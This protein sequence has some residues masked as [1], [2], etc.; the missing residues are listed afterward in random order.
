MDPARSDGRRFFDLPRELRDEIYKFCY[1]VTPHTC[2]ALHGYADIPSSAL[3][4][5]CKQA[6]QEASPI[7]HKGLK[8][9]LLHDRV[10]F[11]LRSDTEDSVRH[12]GWQKISNERFDIWVRNGPDDGTEVGWFVYL[13][14]V[15]QGGVRD[16]ELD[17][18]I[19]EVIN[20]FDKV[21]GLTKLYTS[22]PHR[23]D[24][25]SPVA[26]RLDKV[27]DRVCQVLRKTLYPSRPRRVFAPARTS[28]CQ[29]QPI[30]LDIQQV[31][32]FVHDWRHYGAV[33]VGEASAQTAIGKG[34]SVAVR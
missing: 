8:A 14:H 1:Q 25:W 27:M 6:Y 31:A 5:T 24:Y 18:Y 34:H 20:L 4:R 12:V 19:E 13:S 28:G 11:Q 33:P 21:D 30:G 10:R 32:G 9:A 22:G 15:W 7:Y 2:G 23:M 17:Y 26:Q 16:V 29:R 3:L